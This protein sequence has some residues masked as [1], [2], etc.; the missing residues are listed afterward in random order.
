M[1]VGAAGEDVEPALLERRGERVGV[2]ADLALVLAERVGAGDPEA[3]RL[4]GDRVHERATLHPGEDRAVDR[5]RVLLLAQDEPG[6]RSRQRL[7]RR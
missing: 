7:V 6:A 5:L 1:R 4:G 3:G 2:R